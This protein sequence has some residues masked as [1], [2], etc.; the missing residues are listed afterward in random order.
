MTRRRLA[1]AGHQ[2]VTEQHL[3]DQLGRDA[4]AC[5][6]GLN[7]NASQIIGGQACKVAL[8]TAHGRARGAEDDDGV[9]LWCGHEVSLIVGSLVYFGA[10]LMAPSSRMTSPFSMSFSM[11]CLASLA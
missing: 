11:M 9:L 4:S 10:N 1:L 8:K 6:G 5:D 2:T 7:R 3:A